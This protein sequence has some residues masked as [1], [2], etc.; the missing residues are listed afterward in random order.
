VCTAAPRTKRAY[1]IP[2]A[3][4]TVACGLGF[5][6]NFFAKPFDALAS[7]AQSLRTPNA[8]KAMNRAKCP[9]RCQNEIEFSLEY[10]DDETKGFY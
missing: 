8:G 9:T 1:A 6:I 5:V 10:W 2:R 4:G 7:R 3:L